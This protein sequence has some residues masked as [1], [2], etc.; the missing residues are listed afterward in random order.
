M[1]ACVDGSACLQEAEAKASASGEAGA[2]GGAA[3]G[4]EDLLTV[5]IEKLLTV[6]DVKA[7]MEAPGVSKTRKNKLKTKLNALQVRA[8]AVSRAQMGTGRNALGSH[9]HESHEAGVCRRRARQ[10]VR[11]RRRWRTCKRASTRR[12]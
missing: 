9:R 8:R 6:E 10:R 4:E 11:A 3:G 7:A 1:R 12:G 2:E 5:P